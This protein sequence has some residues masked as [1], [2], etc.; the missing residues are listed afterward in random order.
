[1]GIGVDAGSTPHIVEYVSVVVV[2]MV[3]AFVVTNVVGVGVTEGL[4]V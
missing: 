3:T 2:V 1:M 4:M